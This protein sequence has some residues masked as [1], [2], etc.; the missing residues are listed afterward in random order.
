MT[1]LAAVSCAGRRA[2]QSRG[3]GI[4]FAAAVLTTE[5]MQ[6]AKWKKVPAVDG[7]PNPCLNCPPIVR[8]LD[9]RRHIAVGFGYAGVTCD[10]EEVWTERGDEYA[11]TWTVR[12]AETRARKD[13]DHDWRIVMD[14]PMHGETYQRH[15]QNE[16]V[17]VERNQGFA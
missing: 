3:V 1:A 5:E 10:G 11:N 7:G 13:P 4:G 14:G 2:P 6:W 12:K 8:K 16:W 17:L 9:L 15:G